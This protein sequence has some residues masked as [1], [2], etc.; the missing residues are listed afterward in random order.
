MTF[1]YGIHD[2]SLRGEGSK[3]DLLAL[4][5][6]FGVFRENDGAE[7]DPHLIIHIP[8]V[9]QQ[10]GDNDCGVFTLY[11]LLGNELWSIKFDRIG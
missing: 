1:T 8:S 11:A 7:V 2:V 3:Y 9:Q 6:R 10:D 5:Y 4:I